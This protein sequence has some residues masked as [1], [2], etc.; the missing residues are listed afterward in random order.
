[1]FWAVST[2]LTPLK[3]GG[4]TLSLTFILPA[5]VFI[6][7]ICFGLSF[8]AIKTFGMRKDKTGFDALKGK[9]GQVEKLSQ[10]QANQG[11]IFIN[12]ESWRFRSVD[13]VEKGDT[14]KILSVKGMTLQVKKMKEEI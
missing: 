7:L 2:C 4:Y 11:W 14:V 8:L 3:T 5:A 1:M 12:G 13:K 9:E 6:G 10:H